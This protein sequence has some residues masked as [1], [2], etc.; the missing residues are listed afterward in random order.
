MSALIAEPA[1]RPG[2]VVARIGD[3]AAF[4]GLRE[5]W[6][7]LL[8]ASPSDCLF[9]TWEWLASWWRHLAD[10]RRLS[11]IT[12]RLGGQLIGLAP[13]AIRPRSWRRLLPFEGVEFLG[14]GVAG[15]DY[16]DVIARAGHERRVVT[17]VGDVLARDHRPL[18]LHRVRRAASV[19]AALAIDLGRRRWTATERTIDVCPFVTLAGHSWATYLA[20]LGSAHR[21]NFQRRL[22]NLTRQFEVRFEPAR[23][24]AERYQA[25]AV[26]ADLH[27]RRWRGR[28]GSESFATPALRAFYAEVSARALERGWLR[29][30]VLTLDGRPAAALHGYRYGPTFSF[31]QA[32]FDPALAKHSVGL[33]AMGLS[34]KH[35]I[36][37]G[38]GEYDLLHGAE[39]Y[40]FQWAPESRELARIEAFPES[41]RGRATARALDVTRAARRAARRLLGDALANRIVR[42]RAAQG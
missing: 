12:V 8:Q 33:V 4:E 29:L 18:E 2:L 28:G 37:E 27:E 31:Y 7:E 13:L 34:I 9:L 39:P 26:L 11:V 20:S 41:A 24:E 5:E 21:Y 35:A 15:S 3:L 16:L 42:G 40:K 36:E 17:A 1:V 38:V 32:G 14:G 25:L 10:A 19:A 30:F 23:T 22:K 6:T